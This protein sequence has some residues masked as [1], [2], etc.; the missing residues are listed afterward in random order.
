MKAMRKILLAALLGLVVCPVFA[1][2]GNDIIL[3]PLD[4]IFIDGGD[5]ST[6]LEPSA[7]IVNAF[8]F[9]QYPSATA[10]QVV[11]INESTN[12]TVY[13]DSFDSTTQVII[14]LEYE[15]IGEGSYLL[16]I[17][18]FGKWWWGEFVLEDEKNDI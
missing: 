10:S 17:Y 4:S 14:D 6:V 9:L 13:S 2:G 16:H 8:L 15:G 3:L 5:R 7:E 11:I 18:A 1:G 12:Q